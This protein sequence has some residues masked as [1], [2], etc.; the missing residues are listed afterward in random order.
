MQASKELAMGLGVWTEVEIAVSEGV[1]AAERAGL[2]KRREEAIFRD[3]QEIIELVV[4]IMQTE[5][6]E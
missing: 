5:I 4:M 1:S 3:D 6:L 2:R